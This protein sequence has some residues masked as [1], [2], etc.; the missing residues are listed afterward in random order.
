MFEFA[1]ARL[2]T[3][4]PKDDTSRRWIA[5][6]RARTALQLLILRNPVRD[7]GDLAAHSSAKEGIGKS[8]L[9][10]T[11]E[12]ERTDMIIIFKTV[13]GEEPAQ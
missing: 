11:G 12:R 13:Y 1:L 9:A 5:L 7:R 6:S 2:R 3:I 4:T 8:I 10:L